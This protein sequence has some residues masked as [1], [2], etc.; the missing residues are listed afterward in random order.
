MRLAGLIALLLGSLALPF[1]AADPAPTEDYAATI[2]PLLQKYCLG[3]H[4]TKAKKGSLDL[5]RFTGLDAIRKD[6]KPWQGLIEQLEA[7]EMPPKGKPQ[8]TAA[9]KQKLLAWVKQFLEAEARANKG[10]P[11]RVPLRRL[12]NAEF[13]S[14]IRDLTGIDLR[15]TRE[16]PADGA[17]GEGFT[18]A[19]EAL[20]D[21]SPALLTKYL[22]AA[23]GIADHVVL[24]PDG[25]R[26]SKGTTRRD[27]TD[28]STASLRAFY[29]QF[30][31][32]GKLN[33]AP[34]LAAID[35][36]RDALAAGKLSAEQ[37]ALQERLNA[38]YLRTLWTVL[39][40]KSAN[41][42]LDRLQAAEIAAWQAILWKFQPIGSYRYGNV[43]RQVA[44]EPPIT[45][46]RTFKFAT[47]P[48]PGQN[49]VRLHLAARDLFGGMG[50]VVWQRPRFEAPGKPPLLL[51]DY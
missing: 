36:H 50:K 47:K 35:R 22:N 6:T 10:D 33:A 9:E 26:F 23:K 40:D 12:S 8:P 5:E 44:M 28:E 1:D 25:F 19:A 45:A 49:E 41:F 37:L 14:T 13:D 18:N 29:A 4:S 32:D 2:R 51:K 42:P 27:W 7:G 38:K 16:F 17:A 24:L 20:T 11:G 15:P 46:T 3:C 31:P 39:G 21:I 34:Y 30:A 43:E 48:V